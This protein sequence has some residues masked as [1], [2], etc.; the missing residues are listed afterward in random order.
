QGDTSNALPLLERGLQI[1]EKLR[2]KEHPLVATILN[3]LAS[4]HE[5][6]GKIQEA[7]N[8]YERSL[9]ITEGTFGRSHPRVIRILRNIAVLRLEQGDIKEAIEADA[10]AFRRRRSYF[11]LQFSEATDNEA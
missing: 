7:L 11:V 1:T 3:N 2:G 4:I 5:S 10:K 6:Q 9:T 8:Y